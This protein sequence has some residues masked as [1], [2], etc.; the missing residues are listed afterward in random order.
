ME[1]VVVEIRITG[2][3]EMKMDRYDKYV[4]CHLWKSFSTF[5][6]VKLNWPCRCRI[7]HWILHCN[8]WIKFTSRKGAQNLTFQLFF[9]I[10]RRLFFTYN[11]FQKLKNIFFHTKNALKPTNIVVLWK[12][13]FHPYL[14]LLSSKSWEENKILMK[15]ASSFN[16]HQFCS[17]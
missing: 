14:N 9:S 7:R 6:Q 2:G 12:Y 3:V 13:F 16:E 15:S 8:I 17:T 5:I 4:E 11:I 10:L 1:V